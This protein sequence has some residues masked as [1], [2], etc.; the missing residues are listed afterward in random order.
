MTAHNHSQR[1]AETDAGPTDFVHQALRTDMMTPPELHI[2]PV[3]PADWRQFRSARLEALAE[4]PEMFGSTLSREEAFDEQEWRRRAARPVSF[5]ASRGDQVIGLTGVHEFD[6]VWV[7][8]GM[9]V[10][11]GARG[12]GVVDA[13]MSACEKVARQAGAD[14][15]VLGV[16]EENKAGVRAYRRLG[17]QPTGASEFVCDKGCELWM[18]KSLL[19]P[20]TPPAG[21]S[22]R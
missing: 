7:V 6:G 14:T 21:E 20:G 4:S 8:V 19:T 22:T 18:R 2:V 13:L 10:P 1:P 12:T 16:M 9:W 15:L 3:G 5:L 17:F 11:P